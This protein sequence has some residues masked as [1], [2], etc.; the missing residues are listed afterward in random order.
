MST[1]S[2]VSMHVA[3]AQH[4]REH[5]PANGAPQGILRPGSA[6][7]RLFMLLAFTIAAAIFVAVWAV[8]R[9][10]DEFAWLIALI[11]ASVM[12]LVAFAAR[13][14]LMRRAW[15]NYALALERRRR[16]PYP[17][18][19]AT[20][21]GEAAPRARVTE[22]ASSQQQQGQR[23]PTSITSGFDYRQGG[24]AVLRE[25]EHRLLEG[26]RA[27]VLS[28]EQHL[29]AFHWCEKYLISSEQVLQTRSL[30]PEIRNA[31]RAHQGR[32]RQ[33]QKREMLAWARGEAHR[34]TR[35]A[36][37][38]TQVA[39]KVRYIQLAL[40]AIEH[41]SSH[42]SREAE[43]VESAETLQELIASFKVNS[44]VELG[45]RAA[46]KR[47]FEQAI[48][49]YQDALFFLAR[50]ELSDDVRER[51]S[52]KIGREIDAL[53]AH[54]ATGGLFD[55]DFSRSYESGDLDITEAEA[56]QQQQKEMRQQNLDQNFDGTIQ[57]SLSEV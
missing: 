14:A 55:G 30:A 34:L 56:R 50:A 32:A 25:F 15:V 52:A 51:M 49:H 53:R 39:D 23:A 42:Y 8:L 17:L 36:H 9:E 19:A 41:A 33:L 29:E 38:Q 4:A 5:A 27:G 18:L 44:W 48:E 54:L 26:E 57:T 43:L 35:E 24:A 40:G 47:Q 3:T 6:A 13:E 37:R 45:E 16:Q 11:I 46:F 21:T 12:L 2:V 28:P 1:R 10:T 31:L 20:Q 7:A 22:A